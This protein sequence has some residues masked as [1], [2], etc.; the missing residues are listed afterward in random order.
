MLTPNR[1]FR[2][3][4]R[5]CSST[6]YFNLLRMYLHY[7]I[8]I[9]LWEELYKLTKIF[10]R[11]FAVGFSRS[12]TSLCSGW[13]HLVCPDRIAKPMTGHHKFWRWILAF[14]GN[15]G[16]VS[17][18][19]GLWKLVDACPSGR[20]QAASRTQTSPYSLG[21]Y[22]LRGSCWDEISGNFTLTSDVENSW[23]GLM[24]RA[25]NRSDLHRVREGWPLKML[26]SDVH[27]KCRHVQIVGIS[28]LR[29]MDLHRHT[30][31]LVNRY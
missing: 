19:T 8:T 9:T 5:I 30:Y 24:Q 26:R 13:S 28:Y 17:C 27:L 21:Q 3:R 18:W 31:V 4:C 1:H 29:Q 20:Y 11:H 12:V 15:W 7:C 10:L 14:L 16:Q 22:I 2:V 23:W 6:V 25:R